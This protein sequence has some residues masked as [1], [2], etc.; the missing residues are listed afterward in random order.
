MRTNRDAYSLGAAGLAEATTTAGAVKNTNALN[1]VING[2]AY[3]KA[4][5][6]DVAMV[7]DASSAFVTLSAKKVSVFFAFLDTAGTLTF[8]QSGVYDNAQ[9]AGHVSRAID[10]PDVPNKACIGAMKVETNNAATYTPNVTDL[11]AADVVDTFYN[12]ADDYGVPVTI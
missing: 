9:A 3:Q 12:V 10:W 6:T 8:V 2:R 7:A 1:Y 11:S 4:A 5:T